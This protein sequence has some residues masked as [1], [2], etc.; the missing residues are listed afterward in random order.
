MSHEGRFKGAGGQVAVGATPAALKPTRAGGHSAAQSVPR[1]A[2]SWRQ[3]TRALSAEQTLS[4]HPPG[5]PILRL[6]ISVS[7]TLTET[8]WGSCSQEGVVLLPRGPCLETVLVVTPGGRGC[9][10]HLAGRGQGGCRTSRDAQ[11]G[12]RTNSDL[13]PNVTSAEGQ[14]PP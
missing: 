5:G 11:D 3:G 14:A 12:P 10:W 2:R 13:A 7:C 8:L 6:P 1:G 9:Y 4:Q